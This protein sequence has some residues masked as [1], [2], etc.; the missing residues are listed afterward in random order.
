MVEYC[1]GLV[2]LP[3]VSHAQDQVKLYSIKSPKC[4]D[5]CA[6]STENM[7]IPGNKTIKDPSIKHT[8]EL[9]E[10]RSFKIL[11]LCVVSILGASVDPMINAI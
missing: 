5:C 1:S 9:V 11:L 4:H 3:F 7:P 2:G 8:K 6:E 10:T